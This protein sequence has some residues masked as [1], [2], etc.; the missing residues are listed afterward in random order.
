MSEE[1]NKIN[2][3]LSEL[4]EKKA[5]EKIKKR[6]RRGCL[7]LCILAGIIIATKCN[8]SDPSESQKAIQTPIVGFGGYKLEEKID[9][10][11]LNAKNFADGYIERKAA[12]KF[13]DFDVIRL[14]FTPKTFLVYKIESWGEGGE[15]TFEVIRA[16]IEKKYE[17]KMIHFL[18]MYTLGRN[19][20]SLTLER[21]A[22]EQIRLEVTD[23]KLEKQNEKEKE[24]IIQSKADSS[25]L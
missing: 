7:F 25:G 2:E 22:F 12:D 16:S 23:K 5:A 17:R 9:Q 19:N 24:E 15:E 20:K 4:N 11:T 14:Y 21:R 3:L 18:T 8:L 10:N 6:N 13:R 1:T